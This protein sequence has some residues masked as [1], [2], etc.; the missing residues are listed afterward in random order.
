MSFFLIFSELPRDKLRAN[1]LHLQFLAI[2]CVYSSHTGIKLCTY[3]LHRH[4]TVLIQEIIYL[5][6]Q[7]WCY[8]FLTPPTPLII[9]HRLTAFLESLMPLK[10]W[11]SI[12]AR[13]SKSSLKH[14]IGFCGIFPSLKQNLIAY[15]SSSVL[16]SRLHFW[17]S[18]AMLI[19]L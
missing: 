13:C 5:A 4:T 12:H 17:N 11:F 9:P 6:T 1:L 19:R 10:N 2:N 18:P 14:S 7:L 3:C 16:T 15:R 8:D